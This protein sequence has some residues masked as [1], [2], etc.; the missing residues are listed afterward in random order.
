MVIKIREKPRT[1]I[2]YSKSFCNKA[3]NRYKKTR[4]CTQ[5]NTRNN[6]NSLRRLKRKTNLQKYPA[7]SD[8]SKQTLFSMHKTTTDRKIVTKFPHV[9]GKIIQ[10]YQPHPTRTTPIPNRK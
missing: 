1:K 2:A 7:K 8:G 5:E 10:T 4:A 9:P 6:G 3:S